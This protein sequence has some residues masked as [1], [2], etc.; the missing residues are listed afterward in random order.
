MQ[1][2]VIL[3]PFVFCSACFGQ[4]VTVRSNDNSSVMAFRTSSGTISVNHASF[5]PADVRDRLF[6]VA[7]IRRTRPPVF[8][9]GTGEPDHFF[10]RRGNKINVTVRFLNQTEFVV[11]VEFFP[12][13]SGLPVFDSLGRVVGVALGNVL[14]RRPSSPKLSPDAW[15]GR[16]ARLSRVPFLA[17][18]FS[19]LEAELERGQLSSARGRVDVVPRPKIEYRTGLDFPFPV[20]TDDLGTPRTLNGLLEPNAIP[21][22]P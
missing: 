21:A 4:I 9:F 20:P 10:D 16:V 8:R 15:L 6:D 19:A 13:E 22:L 17:S 12:G 1:Q 7:V 5:F 11:D 2:I 14:T 3:L 18:E